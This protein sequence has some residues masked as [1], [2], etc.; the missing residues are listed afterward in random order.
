MSP[1]LGTSKSR[2]VVPHAFECL[3]VVLPGPGGGAEY[4]WIQPLVLCKG[5]AERDEFRAPVRRMAAEFRN[6]KRETA[7]PFDRAAEPQRGVLR[8]S[9]PMNRIEHERLD[10]PA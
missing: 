1:H 2:H 6:G 9:A 7:V 5:K 4:R 10:I 8:R 3:F